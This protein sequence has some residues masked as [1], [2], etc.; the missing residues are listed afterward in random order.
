MYF[1]LHTAVPL[2]IIVVDTDADLEQVRKHINQLHEDL[3][4]SSGTAA[5]NLS[6]KW[7]FVDCKLEPLYHHI[8]TFL[9]EYL[10]PGTYSSKSFL[11]MMLIIL[12]KMT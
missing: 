12:S 8:T 6:I 7:C 1:I 2:G 3:V 5:P 4:K 10:H 9:I 11:D